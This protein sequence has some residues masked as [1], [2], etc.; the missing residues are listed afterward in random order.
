MEERFMRKALSLA[1]EAAE[2]G[3]VPVGAVVVK[4]GEIVGQG[5]N[6]RETCFDATAH[7]EILAIREACRTLG[8]RRLSGCTLYVTLEPCPMCAGAVMNS[9][10]DTL[11]FGAKDARGGAMGS[12]VNLCRYPFYSVPKVLSGVLEGECAALLG[13][14]F[15]QKRQKV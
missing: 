15:R 8:T 4:D 14:F 5:G 2:K 11:V 12:L 10:I 9:G 6:L 13:D 1:R 3:E 7:A